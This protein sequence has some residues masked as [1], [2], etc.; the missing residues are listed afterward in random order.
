MKKL[1]LFFVLLLCS[2]TSVQ[3]IYVL[4]S[5]RPAANPNYILKDLGDSGLMVSF[6]FT[7]FTAIVDK[8]DSTV[9]IPQN[10]E[11][12]TKLTFDDTM[13]LINV[14]VEIFNPNHVQYIFKSETKI[15]KDEN[16]LIFTD[17]KQN[18]IG[19]SNLQFRSYTITLPAGETIISGLF[20]GKILVDGQ[21]IF[22][23][24]PFTYERKIIQEK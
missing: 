22:F 16:N 19:I 18:I 6:Y 1:I 11:M 23:M 14:H 10:H 15:K 8:D 17:Y 24:G 13:V 7:S 9:L 20:K 12:L 21:S 5:G 2:C 4:N 3:P